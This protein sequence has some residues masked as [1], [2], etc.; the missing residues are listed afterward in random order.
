MRAPISCE[1]IRK[2]YPAYTRAVRGR[3]LKGARTYG[4]SSFARPSPELIDEMAAEALDIS[5]WGFILWTRLQQL[6]REVAR[7]EKRLARLRAA[8][9]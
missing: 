9:E 7:E 1:R 5:G 4:D 3:L 2:K 8:V 6:R